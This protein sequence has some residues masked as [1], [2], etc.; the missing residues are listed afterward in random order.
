MPETCALHVRRAIWQLDGVSADINFGVGALHVD[1]LRAI[2][3]MRMDGRKT[4]ERNISNGAAVSFR[5][6][7]RA[8]GACRGRLPAAVEPS[9]SVRFVI[10]DVQWFIAGSL[11]LV[12]K[13]AT[14]RN[15]RADTSASTQA[16][17]PEPC[18]PRTSLAT[19]PDNQ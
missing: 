9:L 14:R 2:R 19:P 6:V 16:S 11:L 3:G 15:G 4:V 5:L 17:T 12:G 1:G 7:T 18:R 13:S 8:D 10:R